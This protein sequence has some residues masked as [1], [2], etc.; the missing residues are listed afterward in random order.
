[1]KSGGGTGYA[2]ADDEN[3][4]FID[5]LRG[6][7]IYFLFLFVVFLLLGWAFMKPRKAILEKR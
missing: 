3:V 2:A 7:P 6:F 4:G 1:M 5:A